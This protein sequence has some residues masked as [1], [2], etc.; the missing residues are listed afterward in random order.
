MKHLK[1][2]E[3]YKV[4][5]SNIPV[6]LPKDLEDQI[7][8]ALGKDMDVDQIVLKSEDNGR[9]Y[10]IELDEFKNIENIEDLEDTNESFGSKA[11]KALL[12]GAV[13]LI[14]SSGIVSCSSTNKVHRSPNK[15]KK[16][17][18]GVG[19]NRS[20]TCAKRR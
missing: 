14:L 9:V 12:G 5:E 3:N 18:F 13:L 19:M 2:F 15:N 1:K 8:L 10:L 16:E 17:I 4:N 6:D 7:K 11:R 20:H